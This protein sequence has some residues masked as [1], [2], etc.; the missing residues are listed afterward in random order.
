MFTLL[1]TKFVPHMIR[2]AFFADAV[3]IPLLSFFLNFQLW[4]WRG[5][6]LLNNYSIDLRRIRKSYYEFSLHLV[7]GSVQGRRLFADLVTEA[8]SAL[9]GL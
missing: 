7:F 6:G 2:L 4:R 3:S 1:A 5:Q 8:L 9:F